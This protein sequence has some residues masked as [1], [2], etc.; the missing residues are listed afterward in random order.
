MSYTFVMNII[1][2]VRPASVG[3]GLAFNKVINKNQ[4]IKGTKTNMS[5][6]H[7]T[8]SIK[9]SFRGVW[10]KINSLAEALKRSSLFIYSNL[11]NWKKVIKK[12]LKRHHRH[13]S[14]L[15]ILLI[16]ICLVK[17]KRIHENS[18]PGT[19]WWFAKSS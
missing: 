1:L 18:A 3:N 11:N 6:T 14:F 4:V 10:C 13:S 12:N 16:N 5:C 15:L 9:M 17:F 7:T 2:Q 8:V 19:I